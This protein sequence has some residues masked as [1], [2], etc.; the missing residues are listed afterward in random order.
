[1]KRLSLLILLCLAWL[2]LPAAARQVNF[3]ATTCP[4]PAPEQAEI[5]C[6]YLTVPESRLDPSGSQISLAVAIVYSSSSNPLPDPVVYLEGGPGGSPLSD[7]ESWLASPILAQRNLILFDQRGTGYSDPF[8]GCP[9]PEDEQADAI[10]AAQY[11]KDELDAAGINLSAYNSAESAADI[12]DLRLALGIQS[13]NV[14]GISYGTRL[15]LTLLRNYP[16]GIRSVVLDSVNPPEVNVYEDQ[17]PNA[18]GA[19]FRLFEDCAAS[20]A[21]N[22]AYPDLE[23]VFYQTVED[24]NN[25]PGYVLDPESGEEIEFWGDDLANQL[26]QFLYSAEMIPYLPRMIYE[27]SEGYFDTYDG[28][29]SGELGVIED[30]GGADSFGGYAGDLESVLEQIPPD[31]VE[32]MLYE[33]DFGSLDEVYAY[34]EELSDD[35]YAVLVDELA[36]Y[37][38]PEYGGVDGLDRSDSDGMYNSVDCSEELP[39]NAYDT[40]EAMSDLPDVPEVVEQA[41]FYSVADQFSICEIWDVDQP[42]ALE[43]E[44]VFSDIPVLLMTGAYDPITPPA[45]ANSAASGLSQ[46]RLILFPTM[47]H[48]VTAYPCGESIMMQF[49]DD[50]GAD[51]DTDCIAP[52]VDF[53][54]Q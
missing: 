54:T 20:P 6:G 41:L 28:L 40:A 49:L 34:A 25:S 26:M 7:I 14:Y 50:P 13:W 22:A 3:E 1:M 31:V 48:G 4:F 35:E 11:C 21:C 19:F 9:A 38:L 24:L 12:N 39:F 18:L 53:V 29:A 30:T 16:D 42:P 46:G 37:Y 33:Y 32:E 44:R 52:S 10:D 17:T 36:Y 51:L 27:A 15:G 8:L 2:A 5:D 43:N 45:W 23:A 47:G